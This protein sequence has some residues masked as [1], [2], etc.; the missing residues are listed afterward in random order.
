MRQ[1]A[2]RQQLMTA[3]KEQSTSLLRLLRNSSR[4][5]QQQLASKST[6]VASPECCYCLVQL[7]RQLSAES[8]QL[9]LALS[10][11]FAGIEGSQS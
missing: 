1:P 8:R 11:H 10:W 3:I 6:A 9:N 7:C 4:F 2:T 5:G